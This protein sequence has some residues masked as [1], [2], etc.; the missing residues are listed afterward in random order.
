[1]NVLIHTHLWLRKRELGLSPKQQLRRNLNQ[2]LNFDT[3]S[4]KH[5]SLCHAASLAFGT[6]VGMSQHCQELEGYCSSEWVEITGRALTYH[7]LGP[8]FSPQDKKDS[9]WV[10]RV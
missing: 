6:L 10:D 2:A 8:E 4:P 3:K 9:M 5:F 7:T 1:M